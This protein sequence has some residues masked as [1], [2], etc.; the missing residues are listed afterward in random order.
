[1]QPRVLAFG[2]LEFAAQRIHLLQVLMNPAL[3]NLL[4]LLCA[5]AGHHRFRPPRSILLSTRCNCSAGALFAAGYSL[6]G[7]MQN[8]GLIRSPAI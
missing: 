1:M 2:V 5:S 7:R 8:A 4:R 6:D 3:K